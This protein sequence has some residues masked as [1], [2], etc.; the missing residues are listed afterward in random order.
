MGKIISEAKIS[1]VNR[2]PAWKFSPFPRRILFNE[3]KIVDKFPD[4]SW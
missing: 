1:A 2:V 3:Y 4:D